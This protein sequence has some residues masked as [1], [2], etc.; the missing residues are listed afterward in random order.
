MDPNGTTPT[1]ATWVQNP[2]DLQ[3][4]FRY[5][6]VYNTPR[7]IHTSLMGL[8]R[9]DYEFLKTLF[10]TPQITHTPSPTPPHARTPPSTP[11]RSR[12]P[13]PPS[14]TAP[15]N[16]A[17]SNTAP[18]NTAPSNTA[19]PAPEQTTTAP[20]I[21]ADARIKIV[22]RP[23]AEPDH[24]DPTLQ[25]LAT[26]AV[27]AAIVPL[28][29]DPKERKELRNKQQKEAEEKRYQEL[30]AKGIRPEELLTKE[31]LNEWIL[32]KRYTFAQIARELVGLPESQIASIAT[33]YGIRSSISLKRAAIANAKKSS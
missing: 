28:F 21:K 7:E 29:P 16:T 26:P 19:T 17:P 8:L 20:K 24:V 13:A 6:M 23:A 4:H 25:L 33:Q 3:A 27:P 1:N 22:K 15:S 14:N 9:Q 10:D 18:S 12:S 32:Q 11:A 30:V 2:A 5:M 31:N